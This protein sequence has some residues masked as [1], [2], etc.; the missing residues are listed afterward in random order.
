M[1]LLSTRIDGHNIEIEFGDTAKPEAVA[2]RV[3]IRMPLKGDER[4][5]LALHQLAAL[6][7]AVEALK[8]HQMRLHQI[9]N[10]G[11]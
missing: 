1:K 8:E 4:D 2:P 11:K 6:N 3:S 10:R 5:S 7:D 9:V